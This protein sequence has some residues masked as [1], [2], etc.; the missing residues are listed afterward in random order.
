MQIEDSLIYSQQTASGSLSESRVS[1]LHTQS[2]FFKV[3][4]NIVTI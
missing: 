3:L 4:Y 2:Y 1:N